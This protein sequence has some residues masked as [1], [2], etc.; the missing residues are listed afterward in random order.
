MVSASVRTYREGPQTLATRQRIVR[1]YLNSVPLSA[2]PGHGEVHGIA[3]GLRLWFGADF[4]EV[5]RLLDP[6]SPEA[7]DQQAVAALR[8]VLSL[9]IAQRRPSYYRARAARKWRP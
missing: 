5:N 6:R 3:D 9:L 8:Q 4:R 2:A 1:D 7:V